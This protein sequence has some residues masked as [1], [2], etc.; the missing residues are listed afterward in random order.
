MSLNHPKNHYHYW[1]FDIYA[2]TGTSVSKMIPP[3][4]TPIESTSFKYKHSDVI[5]VVAFSVHHYETR[6]ASA[7]AARCNASRKSDRL[8]S[9]GQEVTSRRFRQAVNRTQHRRRQRRSSA[10]AG[11]LLRHCRLV[12]DRECA[13][14][15]IITSIAISKR[16]VCWKIFY[17][18]VSE[19]VVATNC[20]WLWNIQ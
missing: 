11:S 17:Y 14:D 1:T 16:S 5:D 7:A 2:K 18:I 3:D 19:G 15:T 6:A 8:S 9:R 4:C 12:P 10:D 13:V 20:K